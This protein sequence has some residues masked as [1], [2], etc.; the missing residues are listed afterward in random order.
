[1]K[2]YI[3]TRYGLYYPTSHSMMKWKNILRSINN[4]LLQ[5][6]EMAADIE[7]SLRNLRRRE[8]QA[9]LYEKYETEWWCFITPCMLSLLVGI[10]DG[11][12][13]PGPK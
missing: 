6:L 12:P 7:F 3:Y 9:S 5:S 1:M 11:Q 4:V 2:K 8:F 13:H 10:P